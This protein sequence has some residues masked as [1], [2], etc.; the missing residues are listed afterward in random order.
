VIPSIKFRIQP[1]KLIVELNERGFTLKDVKAVCDTGKSSKVDD[2][3]TT[4]EKGLGFKSVFAV[5]RIV[6]IRSGLWS[7]RF[8][9]RRGQDGVGMVTPIW[10]TTEDEDESLQLQ[11]GTRYSLIYADTRDSFAELLIAEFEKLPK[12]IIYALRQLERLEIMVENVAGRNDSLVLTRSGRLDDEVI[13]VKSSV[14]GTFGDHLSHVAVFQNFQKT[15]SN[16]PTEEMRPCG[17]SKVNIA[18]ETDRDGNPVIPAR[19]QHVFAYLPVQRLLQL[20]VSSEAGAG[21]F[22]IH[23]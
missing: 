20:P 13:R 5:A 6:A 16:L 17:Q 4:G 3:G 18:F 14:S 21:V 15:I 19:G 22:E 7:F 12:T 11:H 9:H 2:S 10:T 1:K 23:D 8:E